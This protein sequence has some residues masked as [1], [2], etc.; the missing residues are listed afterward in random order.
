MKEQIGL[1]MDD[2]KVFVAIGAQNYAVF[3]TRDEGSDKWCIRMRTNQVS[4]DY[5]IQKQRGGIRLFLHLEDAIKN[6]LAGFPGIS[7]LI[8]R[9]GDKELLL[10]GTNLA[11]IVQEECPP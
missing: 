7:N 5:Y 8:I 9:F 6:V 11:N 1:A 10:N 4:C 2:M 3:I